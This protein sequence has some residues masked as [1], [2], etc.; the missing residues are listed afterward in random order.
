[1]GRV[2]RSAVQTVTHTRQLRASR[3][4]KAIVLL[5]Y[6][7]DP[8]VELT[9]N[10]SLGYWVSEARRYWQVSDFLNSGINGYM[11]TT[12]Q[13]ADSTE[14]EL[15][16]I[17]GQ[18]RSFDLD[19]PVGNDAWLS[20]D[21]YPEPGDTEGAWLQPNR[22]I[23]LIPYLQAGLILELRA[24][25]G[26]ISDNLSGAGECYYGPGIFDSIDIPWSVGSGTIITN[27]DFRGSESLRSDGSDLRGSTTFITG[28]DMPADYQL[29]YYVGEW[30]AL[31]FLNQPRPRIW[32]LE[33]FMATA[34]NT[35]TLPL[36]MAHAFPGQAIFVAVLSTRED[37]TNPVT[38]TISG[39]TNTWVQVADVLF[40]STGTLR[41]RLTLFRSEAEAYVDG[42]LH[43]FIDDNVI[44]WS[45][46]QGTVAYLPIV[47]LGLQ[48]GGTSGSA[49]VEQSATAS[50]GADTPV[51]A[52]L[53]AFA[54][55]NNVT[56]TVHAKTREAGSPA[57]FGDADELDSW[58]A[59]SVVTTAYYANL[60]FGVYYGEDTS[61]TE[62]TTS[63]DASGIIAVELVHNP[64]NTLPDAGSISVFG[65]G[66]HC[67]DSEYQILDPGV[68]YRWA[69][70]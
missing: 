42:G 14:T 44:N 67:D 24:N 69:A 5:D 40:D 57:Q 50:A 58:D 21:F 4:H 59:F 49:A 66:G 30:H 34:N 39:G 61:P 62:N 25:A 7:D 46:T 16:S 10:P 47:T 53:A 12:Y 18:L 38:P 35:D 63:A 68:D 17:Q 64:L 48:T 36:Y 31:D 70:A 51:S 37:S 11:N 1:M 55:A 6:G 43:A 13:G 54:H 9:Y 3:G 29:K 65:V 8:F 33:D 41:G 45:A 27:L 15:A 32:E 56:L 20:S 28:A 52:T 60:G 26:R 23:N 19:T 22:P 2:T